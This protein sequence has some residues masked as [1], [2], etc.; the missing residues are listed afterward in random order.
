[1][2]KILN[3]GY[4]YKK[5]G[6]LIIFETPIMDPKKSTNFEKVNVNIF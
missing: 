2:V 6:K 4:S 3:E 5:A 1:M